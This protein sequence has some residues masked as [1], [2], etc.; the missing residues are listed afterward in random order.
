VFVTDLF[1]LIST[2]WISFGFGVLFKYLSAW[3][4]DI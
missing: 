3:Q 4:V 2:N 1:S